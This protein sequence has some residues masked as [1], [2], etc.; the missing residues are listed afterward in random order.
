MSGIAPIPQMSV[1][2]QR[3]YDAVA[4]AGPKGIPTNDLIARMYGHD[5]WPTPGGCV[6]IRVQVCY[7]NKLIAPLNQRIVGKRGIGY[8]LISTK[9]ER[10]GTAIK[11]TA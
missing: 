6:V 3:V 10:N 4:G 9:G 5:E 1:R 11:E 7:I 2:M 8:R